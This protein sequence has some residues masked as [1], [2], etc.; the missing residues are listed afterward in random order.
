MKTKGLVILVLI[1]TLGVSAAY[2]QPGRKTAFS[3]T[4]L[5]NPIPIP[6]PGLPQIGEFLPS[7]STVKCPGYEP[8]GDPLQPCPEGSRTHLRNFKWRS[9]FISSTTG[10]SDGWFTVVAN[11]NLDA[12]FTG[13][14]W[15]TYSLELDSGG[16]IEGTYEGVRFKDGNQ[17]V[18]PLHV[19]GRI[20]GGP[21]D[22]AKMLGTDTI[23]S[24][25][26]IPI[27]YIGTVEGLLLMPRK[28]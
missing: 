5:F 28:F 18:T 25:T 20:T 9:R 17:W 14:Q 23:V 16:V 8:T 2:S 11:S 15:G 1:F 7:D 6:V 26:P 13:P 3:G 22:G 4:E 10:M 12:D 27:A 24:F 21:L 19:N